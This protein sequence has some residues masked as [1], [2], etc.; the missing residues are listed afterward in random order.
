MDVRAPSQAEPELTFYNSE[1]RSIE[2]YSIDDITAGNGSADGQPQIIQTGHIKVYSDVM[3]NYLQNEDRR[4][5]L[6]CG[7]SGAGKT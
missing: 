1:R 5:F 2:T 7:P 6:I 3:R 4:P